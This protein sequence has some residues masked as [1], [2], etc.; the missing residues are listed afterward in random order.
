MQNGEVINMPECM[1]IVLIAESCA[2]MSPVTV[3]T[4]GIVNINV[5]N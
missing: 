4:V 1:K 2:I 5:G 3:S